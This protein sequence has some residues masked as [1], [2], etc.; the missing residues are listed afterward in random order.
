VINIYRCEVRT[1]W[2]IASVWRDGNQWRWTL[3]GNEGCGLP[4]FLAALAEAEAA[5]KSVFDGEVAQ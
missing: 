4:D 2:G 5:A 1:D 3:D